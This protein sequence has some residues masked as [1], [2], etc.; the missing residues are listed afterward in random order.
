MHTK[1]KQKAPQIFLL[2]SLGFK[3]ELSRLLVKQ[4]I[5]LI[6]KWIK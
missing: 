5:Y 3:F 1:E 2:R 6:L 4:A